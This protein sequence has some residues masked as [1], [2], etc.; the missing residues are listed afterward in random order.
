[1]PSHTKK[2]HHEKSSWLCTANWSDRRLI[3]CCLI[4]SLIF[5]GLYVTLFYPY[6]ETNDDMSVARIVDGSLGS[7]DP[8]IIIQSTVLGYILCFLYQIAGQIAWYT[9]LQYILIVTAFTALGFCLLRILGDL[10][11]IAYFF[12]LIICSYEGFISIQ[13]T[14][15][16]G[17]LA[18]AGACLLLL[19]YAREKNRIP[20]AIWGYVLLFFAFIYRSN[21]TIIC[22]GLVFPAIFLHFLEDKRALKKKLPHALGYVG[23]ALVLFAVL[24]GANKYSYR[25][26][27][28]KNFFAF[29]DAR[30]ELLDFS[31]PPFSP[32]NEKILKENYHIDGDAYLMLATWCYADPDVFTAESLQAMVDMKPSFDYLNKAQVKSFLKTVIPA[33]MRKRVM[34]LMFAAALFWLIAARHDRRDLLVFLMELAFLGIIYYYLYCNGRWQMNR[35]A[36]PMFLAVTLSGFMMTRPAPSRSALRLGSWTA[37]AVLSTVILLG[38][39]SEDFSP[40][41]RNSDLARQ[42]HAAAGV[43][44]RIVKNSYADKEHFFI[45]NVG[46]ILRDGCYE[47]FDIVPRDMLTNFINLGGWAT[48]TPQYNALMEKHGITNPLRSCIDN[49]NILFVCTQPGL[50]ESYLETQLGCDITFKK[51]KSVRICDDIP[52]YHVTSSK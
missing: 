46:A 8:H 6:F 16:C 22:L 15:T 26:P 7:Y 14:R 1:M 35:I 17:I 50:T 4:I 47:P 44:Q 39:V 23:A 25:S 33:L 13:Y 19:S 3:A 36:F 11:W 28:W 27:Y 34:L 42:K 24:Y 20:V 32:E 51:A 30:V 2:T 12:L 37:A 52:V 43:Y 29:D 49:D 48:Y 31:M 5:M 41:R 45:C 18:T 40:L 9:V 21:M 38:H 10:G